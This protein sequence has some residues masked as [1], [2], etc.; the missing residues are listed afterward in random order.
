M[1]SLRKFAA[2][3]GV[4]P[5][6]VSRVFANKGLVAPRTHARVIALAKSV[7]FRPS[8][9]GNVA[10]GGNTR[11]V[12]VLVA[13]LKV[14]YFADIATG[15]QE[16]LLAENY[17]PM[18][19]QSI[20]DSDRRSIRRLLDHR[21]DALCLG[22]MDETLTPDDFSEV[23]KAKIP[24]VVISPMGSGL[25]FDTASD[26]DIGGGRLAGE[27]L[28]SLGHQRIGFG[29]LGEG[30]ATSSLRQNGFEQALAQHKLSLASRDIARM[31]PR[32]PD[33]EAMF[34][35]DV[36]RILSRPD[37]PTAFFASTDL[38]A[39]NVYH[40][41]RGLNLHI[42][43]DLS[44]VGYADLTFAAHIDPPLTTIR[45]DGLE[46]GRS[47]AEL[48]LNRLGNSTAPR[49]DVMVPTELVT[50]GSTARCTRK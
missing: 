27:H 12:G 44:I 45:Q 25:M 34:S 31:P 29:L 35:R 24:V 22:L 46:L 41:A 36:H 20:V 21:V 19:L 7:A 17:L 5:A 40:V 13:T 3:A 50:R 43:R 38:L 1:L 48:I 9:F 32:G 33:G 47:A 15:L 18:V 8:A 11:S 6:T 37:R 4:S 16:T 26:D 14:T 42:P 10:F 30:R 49:Q 28:L 23:V 39:A 2:M